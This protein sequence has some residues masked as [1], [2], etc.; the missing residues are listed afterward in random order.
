MKT[1]DK[2]TGLKFIFRAFGY[3]NYR[4]FFGGQFISLMGTWMQGI[5]MSW[6]VY[7]LTG[8]VFLL[9]VVGF[10][11][12]IPT[13]FLTPFAGVMTDRWKRLNILIF[14]QT[15]A[16]L[17]AFIIAGLVLT[18]NI[19]VWHIIVLGVWLGIVNAFDMPA[20]QAFVVDMVE[21]KE[22]LSN[23]IALNSSMFNGARL[24][25]PAAAGLLIASRGEGICFLINGISYVFV[26]LALFA[27]KIDG[28]K[29]KRGKIH[30]LQELKEGF[31]YSFGFKPIKYILM[32][33]M[34][35][36]LMGMSYAVLMPVFA[37]E[38]LR[39][40]PQTLGFLVGASGVGALIGALYLA[41]R[42]SVL[43]LANVIAIGAGIFG[44]SLVLFSFSRS[45][46]LSLLLML[47]SGFGMMVQMAASN[48]VLQTILDDDKRGRV[49]SFYTLSFMGMAPFGSL[50][51]GTLAVKFGAPG[52]IIT[53]GVCCIAG[54]ALFASKLKFINKT[55]HH[56]YARM[57]IIPQIAKGMQSAAQLTYPPED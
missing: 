43:G 19:K 5:A 36:S 13:I 15:F 14:T 33:L 51:A 54:A 53:G 32:L 37:K 9:G 39:G 31:S 16:M 52:A 8:S 28:V 2:K 23:A 40:G 27:M 7:R 10:A 55:I 44:A 47:V 18:G 41:S 38:I 34:V 21:K 48:T 24:L 57:G 45:F 3:R 22:D 49:M 26:I 12:Q 56:I 17:Q 29:K 1:H 50:L 11:G 25:G 4:L 20:R 42:K 46:G 6:L 35:I 30:I